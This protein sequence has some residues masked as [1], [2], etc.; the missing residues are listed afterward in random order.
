MKNTQKEIK[1]PIV[2]DAL[3][4]QA[5][6]DW[7]NFSGKHPFVYSY[8]KYKLKIDEEKEELIDSYGYTIIDIT[9]EEFDY[10]HKAYTN[11]E[12]SDVYYCEDHE[13]RFFR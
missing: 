2:K 5:F 8:S 3:H 1:S 4:Y 9:K 13:N 10:I 11:C 7:G 12:I 6:I